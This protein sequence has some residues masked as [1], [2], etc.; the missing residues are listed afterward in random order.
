MCPQCQKDS[1]TRY[2][3]KRKA[4]KTLRW[5]SMD[6]EI[7]VVP[8]R[9]IPSRQNDRHV[10]RDFWIRTMRRLLLLKPGEALRIDWPETAQQNVNSGCYDAARK[11]G[12][13]VSV[14]RRGN[15]SW[16]ERRR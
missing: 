3:N 11:L 16:I 8:A 10:Y 4:Q 13:R 7:S 6:P 5:E 14:T 1:E 9:E 2:A 12:M 15:T